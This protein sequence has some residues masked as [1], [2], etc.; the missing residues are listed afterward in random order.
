MITIDIQ[1]EPVV[2]INDTSVIIGETVF[3]DAYSG[4]IL[5]YEWTPDNDLNCGNC[6]EVIATP[7]ESTYYDIIVTDVNNCFEMTYSFFINVEEAYTLDVPSAFTPNGDGINDVI[8]VDGWGIKELIFFRIYNRF[9]ELVFETNDINKGW[10]GY[11]K[12]NVQNIETFKCVVSVRTYAD[13]I[14]N[15]RA[16]I[17]LIK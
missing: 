7:L 13:N 16:T 17:K 10:D 9:G 15:K 12:G 14:I 4:E 8:Y 6:S 2:N 11:Y 3:L 5:T 1:Y